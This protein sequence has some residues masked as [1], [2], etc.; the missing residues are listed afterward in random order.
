MVLLDTGTGSSRELY[1]EDANDGTR[2]RNPPGINRV[3]LT[4]ELRSKAIT[5]KELS[6]YSWCIAS[7]YVYHFSTVVDFSSEKYS[8]FT[9][10]RN[11]WHQ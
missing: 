9:G 5:G 7:L 2:T 11:S 4:T 10:H 1:S 6:L 8:G 3:P